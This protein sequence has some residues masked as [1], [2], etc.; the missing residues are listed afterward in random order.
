MDPLALSAEQNQQLDGF[1]TCASEP[2]RHTRV[3]FGRFVETVAV[4]A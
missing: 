3:E 1:S 2:V 4:R